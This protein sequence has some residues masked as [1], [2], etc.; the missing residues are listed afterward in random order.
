MQLALKNLGL[1]ACLI[2][3]PLDLFYF[4]GLK[5]SVGKLAVSADA[6]E[7]FVDGRYIQIAQ[8]KSPIPCALDSSN[9]WL[10]FCKNHFVKKLGFDGRH[11][12]YDHFM[13]L[14]KESSG[15]NFISSA[16]LFKSLRAVKD[17]EEIAK[18]R[19]S[20]ALLWKGFQF[21]SSSL[22]NGVTE[23]E[24]SN[25]FKIFCLEHGAEGFSFE[26]IIAFG[27]N[28]AMPHYRSQDAILKTGDSVLIDI[29]V[30][31]DGYHSD[32]TRVLF[33]EQE[34]P[35]LSNLYAITKRAQRAA[36]Q[37]CR[38]E[39]TF[40]QLDAAARAVLKE[41]GVEEL[42][43]HSLGHG[44][45]LEVHEFPR[46]KWD[47]EDKDVVLESGMVFT[48]EPGLYIPGVGGVRYEDTVLITRDGYEN[49]YPQFV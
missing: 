8:E 45:G 24:I 34:D 42:F 9:G 31:L 39:S 26:P 27:S 29:G 17:S 38:P 28:G 13:R 10:D 22:K 11:T 16:P 32:M 20:A 3:Q 14:Q 44:I 18:M 7:L 41:E 5:F 25:R 4:T 47:G 19:K 1:D 6:A 36:L 37:M 15:L 30:I 2:E 33:F 21:I 23:K 35:R 48:V 40:G 46:I 43:I 12:T 49:F